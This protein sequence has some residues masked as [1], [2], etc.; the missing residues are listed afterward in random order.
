MEFLKLKTKIIK[1]ENTVDNLNRKLN[2]QKKK[3]SK[4]ED[5]VIQIIQVE[6]YREKGQII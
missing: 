6:E 5:I 2:G 3:I 4:L 1:M